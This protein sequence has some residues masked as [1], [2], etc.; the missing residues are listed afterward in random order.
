MLAWGDSAISGIRSGLR[1]KLRTLDKP[2]R[3]L[4]LKPSG[5]RFAEV[6]FRNYLVN[7]V[8]Y[9]LNW[10]IG[11]RIRFISVGVWLEVWNIHGRASDGNQIKSR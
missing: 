9:G 2:F 1:W 4:V 8:V 5:V 11:I 7:W 3:F 6:S 10:V